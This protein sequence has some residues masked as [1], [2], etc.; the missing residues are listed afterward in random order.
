MSELL[1]RLAIIFGARRVAPFRRSPFSPLDKTGK[2]RSIHAASHQ[3]VSA[4]QAFAVCNGPP[5]RL[6]SKRNFNDDEPRRS[7][8]SPMFH[9]LEA[10][11][12]YVQ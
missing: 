9:G 7:L 1:E 4:A 12:K 2:C 11:L 6:Y 8:Q 3:L 5:I 10:A